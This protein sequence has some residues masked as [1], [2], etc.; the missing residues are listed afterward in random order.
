[1]SIKVNCRTTIV[2]DG[3]GVGHCLSHSSVVFESV[4]LSANIRA[5]V[6]AGWSVT[7]LAT[8]PNC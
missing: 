7:D 1:M 3:G 8:C 2:C 4:T 6:R 5:A